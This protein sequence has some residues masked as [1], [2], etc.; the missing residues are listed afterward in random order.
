MNMTKLKPCPFC[1]CNDVRIEDQET[2]SFIECEGCL[3][4]FYQREACSVEDNVEAWNKRAIFTKNYTYSFDGTNSSE[5]PVPA[6]IEGGG[7][8]WWYVCGEC[9]TTISSGDKFC[10]ECGRAVKWNG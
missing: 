4:A 9:H 6:E 3:G 1:G 8:N 5:K 7:H 10:R 2:F